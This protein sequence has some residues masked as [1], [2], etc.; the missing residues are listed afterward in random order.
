[1]LVDSVRVTVR[2]GDG[3]NGCVSFRREKFVP[4]GG[5]DGGDG[6]R[7]GSVIL[8]V[9]DGLNTLLYLHHR[10]LVRAERG[11]H[12]KGSNKTGAGGRDVVLKVPPGT[13]V[14]VAEDPK[15]LGDL[16]DEGQE[17]IVAR[18]G[19]GGRGQRR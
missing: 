14:R 9:D 17:M 12:G 15:I 4:R 8:R 18:G 7:G 2:A 5:P 10:R 13:V 16:V 11:Q 1:M 6:G 19:R 3:G